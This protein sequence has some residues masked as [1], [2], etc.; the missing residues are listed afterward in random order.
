MTSPLTHQEPLVDAGVEGR[1]ADGPGGV[2]RFG[3]D[4]VVEGDARTATV[5]VG[6]A[7]GVGRDTPGPAPLG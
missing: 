4:G 5:G 3:L 6:V 7:E 2:E 1:E